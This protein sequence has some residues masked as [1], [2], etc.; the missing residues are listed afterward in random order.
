MHYAE[1][2]QRIAQMA[3]QA[4]AE[5]RRRFAVDTINLLRQ[6]AQPAIDSE[7]TQT[8]QRL[9]VGLLEGLEDLPVDEMRRTLEALDESM[10]YDPVRAIEFDQHL[11]EL[12][13][14]VERWLAYRETGDPGC[15][16]AIAVCGVN[17]VDYAISGLSTEYSIDNMLGAEEMRQEYNR[18]KRLLVGDRELQPPAVVHQKSWWKLW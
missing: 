9:L 3:S 7:M 15:I 14:A 5:S 11:T 13:C 10:I 4:S 18:Q 16:E 1:L 12:V 6:S 2:E 8:E 17:S